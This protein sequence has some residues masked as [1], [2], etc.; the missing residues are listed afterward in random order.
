V[1]ADRQDHGETGKEQRHHAYY[2]ESIE[3]HIA[4]L[5]RTTLWNADLLPPQVL[6]HPLLHTL[7]DVDGST[8]DGG[9]VS[10]PL[11]HHH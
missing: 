8:R 5:P 10:L 2:I 11:S 3:S 6:N 9:C 7:L 1:F 4:Q